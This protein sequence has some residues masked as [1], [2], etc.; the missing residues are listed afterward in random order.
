[1]KNK[2]GD[3]RNH[4]FETIEMLKANDGSMDIKTARAI[5]D[6][7]DSIIGTAKVELEFIELT[8]ATESDFLKSKPATL[9]GVPV[10]LPMKESK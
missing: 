7:A 10:R 2:I 9:E 6:A 3:L 4:L 1:M 8:G 5:K